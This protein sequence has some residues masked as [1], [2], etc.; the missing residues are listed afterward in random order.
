KYENYSTRYLLKIID[1]LKKLGTRLL[2]LHGGESLLR[3]DIGEV[4]NYAKLKGFYISLN[5]NGYLIPN[6]IKELICIDN[7]IL[8]LD[9]REE[10]NDK[11]R[12]KGCYKKVME[13]IDFVLENNIPLVIHATLTKNSIQ[14]MEFLAK[15]AQDKKF[16]VQYSI[17]YNYAEFNDKCPDTVASDTEIRET[18][19]KIW[20]LKK[21]GYPIFYSENVLTT[22]I[23]WPFSYNERF[24]IEEDRSF[25]A[26][27][28]KLLP[29]YHG[30]LKYQIDADGRV[31]TCWA[32]NIPDA[33]NIKEIG[34]AQAIK[35]C[36]D[37]NK[38]RYCTFLANNEHNA[39]IHLIPR[40]IWNI[41]CIQIA[42]VL[43][44]KTSRL[45]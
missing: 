4:I 44:I 25:I 35:Q 33:P 36:R 20:S 8:S 10:N 38:C 30:K 22:A 13:A 41:I 31:V 7:I 43:K 27:I 28:H 24:F 45:K 18:V 12:G 1:E 6:K 17:L 19:K 37:N 39:L 23:N 26:K 5:T 15:L 2:T 16:R 21:K 9:G 29:C 14:D 42:D 32:H 11:N 40:N 34:V 3:K